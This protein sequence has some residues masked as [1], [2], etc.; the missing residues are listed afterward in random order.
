M[1]HMFNI[2]N[3]YL[4]LKTFHIIGWKDA[5]VLVDYSMPPVSFLF[6]NQDDLSSIEGQVTRLSRL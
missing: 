3:L 4:I 5:T 6:D 2:L 1:W